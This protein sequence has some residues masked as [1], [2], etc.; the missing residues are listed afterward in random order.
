MIVGAEF[1]T[2]VVK[3][4]RT[5]DQMEVPVERIVGKLTE[6][7]AAPEYRNLVA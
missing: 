7:F 5:R 2:L 3:N 6:L 4:L 1:P